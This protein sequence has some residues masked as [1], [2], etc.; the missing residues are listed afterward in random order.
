MGK[1]AVNKGGGL[2]SYRYPY[3]LPWVDAIKQQVGREWFLF[4]QLP[5]ELKDKSNLVKAYGAGYLERSKSTVGPGN[6]RRM[7]RVK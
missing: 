3:L 4:N 2:M 7:W 1:L 6:T 5:A